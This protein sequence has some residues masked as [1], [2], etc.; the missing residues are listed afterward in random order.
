MVYKYF[1][2]NLRAKTNATV[3]LRMAPRTTEQHTFTF[4][5]INGRDAY[6]DRIAA[7]LVTPAPGAGE[8]PPTLLFNPLA[9]YPSEAPA[10]GVPTIT[11]STHG[12]G[13]YNSGILDRDA[14]T[15]SPG[16]VRVSFGAAG[17]YRYLCLIHP[18]MRGQ[19]TVSD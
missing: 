2:A 3:T 5:P 11:P 17:T 7:A 4:G 18:F 6:V 12:N 16:E 8:G 19:V 14:A 13:F 1:P 10:T 9:G 15:P